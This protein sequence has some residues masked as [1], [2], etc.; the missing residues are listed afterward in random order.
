MSIFVNVTML[1]GSGVQLEVQT[2][3]SI[4]ALALRATSELAVG[5]GR[6]LTSSGRLL[7]PGET[8]AEAGLQSGDV[9]TLHTR[10]VRVMASGCRFGSAF[11]AILGDGSV[12]TWGDATAGGSSHAV[13]NQLKD[14][15]CIQASRGAFA[16]ILGDGSVVTWGDANSGGDS[17]AVR[18]QLRNVLAIQ[19]SAL[20]F[21]AILQNLGDDMNPKR[22]YGSYTL[23][24]VIVEMG[25]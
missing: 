18:H 19:A 9:L 17:L 8:V 21:A 14:V 7:D 15:H 1:S 12:A 13:Q 23:I 10:Q 6:L 11:A 5:K 3:E 25:I 20:A 2:A 4:E 24:G 22:V 16:A